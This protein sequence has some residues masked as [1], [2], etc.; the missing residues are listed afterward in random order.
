MLVTWI[1]A[2]SSQHAVSRS[3]AAAILLVLAALLL[4]VVVGVVPIVVFR[5]A[6]GGGQPRRP[7][8]VRHARPRSA[9]P[10]PRI[11]EPVALEQPVVALPSVDTVAR[12]DA[13]AVEPVLES[14]QPA[15]VEVVSDRHRDLYHK[16][17][18]R[19][20]DRVETLRDAI[21]TRLAVGVS[22]QPDGA[23]ME[24]NDP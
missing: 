19:Q 6:T 7:P 11:F 15:P 24:A 16:E 13:V 10:H 12:M 5:L 22:S 18:S 17:Y 2:A 4:G 23:A 1:V 20:L 8:A 14:L 3:P 9:R 21:R